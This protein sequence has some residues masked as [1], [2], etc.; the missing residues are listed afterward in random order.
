MTVDGSDQ[1][2][3]ISIADIDEEGAVIDLRAVKVD[4]ES[5]EARLPKWSPD[6]SQLGLLLGNDRQAQIGIVNADGSGYRTV[7]SNPPQGGAMGDYAWSPDGRSL[8]ISEAPEVDEGGQVLRPPS[9]AW[10]LDV[11]TG[12]QAEVAHPVESWQRLAP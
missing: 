2:G 12:E 5:F 6:G 10:T 4:R 7:W 9:K 8:V 3:P 11:V 1:L